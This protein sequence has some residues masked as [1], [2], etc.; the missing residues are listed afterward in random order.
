MAVTRRQVFR[1]GQAL[2]AAAAIP[3]K[4]FG[5]PPRSDLSEAEAD[6]LYSK[7]RFLTAV[8]SSFAVRSDSAA[9]S[10]LVLLNV[11]D[12]TPDPAAYQVPLAV[13]PK[14]PLTPSP[15]LNTFALRFYGAGEPLSQGA[16]ELEH[17]T[18]GRF[19]LFVVPSGTSKYTAIV[20]RFVAPAPAFEPPVR[21]THPVGAAATLETR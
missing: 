9:R 3:A 19:S 1:L 20:N 18:L 12:S 10:W 13:R 7:D 21:L 4:I 11:E 16:Y 6:L 17:A 5:A 2:L 15:K 14:T 8:N